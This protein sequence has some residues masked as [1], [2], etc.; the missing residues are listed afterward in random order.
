MNQTNTLS[1]PTMYIATI[2]LL[3]P[4]I[5]CP[6]LLMTMKNSLWG[7]SPW[8]IHIEYPFLKVSILY[9]LSTNAVAISFQKSGSCFSLDQ[10]DW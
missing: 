10:S 1:F 8:N 9:L 6:L 5:T 4:I 2:Y 3:E 7:G